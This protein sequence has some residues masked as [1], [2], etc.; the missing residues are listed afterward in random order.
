MAK[1][2]VSDA[3]IA[4][5]TPAER[6]ELIARLEQP[7]DELV[8]PAVLTRIRRLRLG[9]MI[10]GAIALIP[11]LVFLAFTLPATYVAHNWP[12][13]WIGF[14]VILVS[15]M[16][17]TAVLGV[18][19]RQVLLLTAFTTGVLLICDAWF[20]VMT[21]GPDTVWVSLATALLAELPLAAVMISGALRIVQVSV[22]R[23]WLLEPGMSLLRLPLLP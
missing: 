15:F 6:R 12:A 17:A 23:L 4:A 11:W 22:R 7:V 13:T 3:A 8:P 20:D 16:A 10:G 9:L 18:L 19:R 2:V 21:A 1:F 14:D 5:M